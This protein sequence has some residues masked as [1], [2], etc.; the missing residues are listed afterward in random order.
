MFRC[1][2]NGSSLFFFLLFFCNGILNGSFHML[3]GC[4]VTRSALWKMFLSRCLLNM[5][6]WEKDV[7]TWIII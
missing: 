5:L 4:V 1:V 2:I 6:E 7:H 3:H